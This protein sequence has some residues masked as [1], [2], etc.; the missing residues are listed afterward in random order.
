ME[1]RLR[2]LLASGNAEA[3]VVAPVPWFPFSRALFGPYASLA[4]TPRYETRSGIQVSHPRY[5][6]L[7]RVGM[8]LA[9]FALAAGS[10]PQIFQLLRRW[11]FDLI[12][13]HYFYPD[14]VA[15]VLLGMVLRK[16][17]AITARGTDVNLIPRYLLPR[18][19]IQFAAAKAATIITVSQALKNALIELDVPPHRITVLRNGVDL[20]LFRPSDRKSLRAR[21]GFDGRALLSVGH[22]IDR[23]GHHIII[24]AMPRLRDFNLTIVGEGPDRAG[25]TG[26][27]KKLGVT[28]RVRFVGEV[29]HDELFQY[30]GAADALILASSREGWPNVLLE[31][32]ACGTPVVATPIWGNPEIVS[33]HAAG[34]LMHDRTPEALADAVEGLFQSLPDRCTTRAFAE[35]FS[36]DSTS[37]GQLEIFREIS[38]RRNNEASG[39]GPG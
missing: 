38:A 11:N 10:F 5:L 19:L 23:K 7:P 14:G 13:A 37:A 20:Q 1:N 30:Y 18:R 15:A 35:R 39:S 25:L 8:L 29:P 26:L 31:A 33:E 32:M 24:S 27:A 16:P 34:V 17:V 6:H 36:W 12:D 22:L 28:D 3:A 4:R 2:Q 9:P 21:L